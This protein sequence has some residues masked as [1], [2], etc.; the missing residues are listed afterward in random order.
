[1]NNE[2]FTTSDF[3]LATC[4]MTLG[5]QIAHLDRSNPQ[6]V[7]VAF[8]RDE[9]LDEIVQSFWRGDLRIEPKAYH[10]NQ[11]LLKSQLYSANP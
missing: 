3:P 7:E 6:R 9:Q 11:K 2:H 5:Y 8:E 1:M 4:L 10:L